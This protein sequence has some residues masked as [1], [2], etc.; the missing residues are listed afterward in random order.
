MGSAEEKNDIIG[1]HLAKIIE[2]FNLLWPEALPCTLLNLS[3]TPFG[4]CILSSFI[5]SGRPMRLDSGNYEPKEEMP[6]YCKELLKALKK[7][8]FLI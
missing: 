6:E 8:A 2:A 4:K 3:S 5:T 7:N 1:T